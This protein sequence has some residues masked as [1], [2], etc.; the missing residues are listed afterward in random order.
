MTAHQCASANRLLNKGHC[1][2]D[3][4]NGQVRVISFSLHTVI[5]YNSCWIQKAKYNISKRQLWLLDLTQDLIKFHQHNTLW[6]K[7]ESIIWKHISKLKTEELGNKVP[8]SLIF[9]RPTCPYL[10]LQSQQWWP[11]FLVFHCRFQHCLRLHKQCPCLEWP[12][13]KQ[14][15]SHPT[16]R[17][18]VNYTRHSMFIMD[19]MQK[20]YQCTVH[21]Q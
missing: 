11:V 13:Q 12:C 9:P 3:L 2:I 10:S 7:G 18:Y 19:L 15:V 4:G 1:Y 21:F 5:I 6:N 16:C 8:E 17:I 14:R 20:S